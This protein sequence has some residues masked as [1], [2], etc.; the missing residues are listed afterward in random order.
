M[1][2]AFIKNGAVVEIKDV[3][4]EELHPIVNNYDQV[5][6]I[7]NEN[8]RP[9]VG[10]RYEDN[11]WLIPLGESG[12]PSMIIT[13]LA[14]RNRFT[15]SEKAVLYTAAATPQGVGLKV[16]LDDLAAATFVDL[17][18]ADTIASVNYLATLGI[19]TSARAT[20][21]LTTVP[22]LVETYKG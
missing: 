6:E 7:T 12:A 10:W 8:P 3:T 2:C 19:I 22:T 18:R 5:V 15:M 9:G 21:I 11:K 20:E 16:Y 4:D 14:F 17:S 1:L 13:R